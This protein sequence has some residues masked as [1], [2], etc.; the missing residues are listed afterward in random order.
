LQH[1]NGRKCASSAIALAVESLESRTHLSV[2]RDAAGWTVV[3]PASDTKVI[4]VS[5]SQGSDS[6]DGLATT[7]PIKTLAK[8]QSLV[9]DGF[10][11]WVL[12]K[13]GDTFESFGR[14]DKHGRSPQEPL[15][16]SAYGTGARPQINSGLNHGFL[17]NANSTNTRRIDNVV[18][19][20]LSFFANGYDGTNDTQGIAGFRLLAPSSNMTIEDCKIVGYKDNIVLG[21]ASHAVTD[22]TIRR[23]EILDSYNL[24][25]PATSHAQGIYISSTGANITIEENVLDHNGWRQGQNA[26][27]T[28]YN[29]NVYVYN[30]ATNVVVQ[31]NI[32]AEGSFYGIKFNSGGTATGNFLVR[33]AENIYLESAATVSDNVITEAVD[34]P[35]SGW[36]IGINTQKAPSATIQH[37]LITKVASTGGS[38]LIGIQL[39][40]NNTPF[41]GTISDNIIYNWK[42]TGIYVATPGNG[43]GSVQIRNTQIQMVASDT[44]ISQELAGAQSNFVYQGNTYSAGTQTQVNRISGTRQSLSNWISKTGE[45]TAKYQTL[46]YP[47]PTRDVGRYSASIG[48]AGTFDD[49]IAKARAMDKTTWNPAYMAQSVNSYMWGGFGSDTS[50]PSIVSTAFG[51]ET[52]P[53]TLDVKFSEN[54]SSP[55][56]IGLA[57]RN[58]ATGQIIPF[59]YSSYNSATTTARFTYSGTL[60]DGDY[61]TTIAAT[62]VTDLSHN[63]LSKD[64][65]STFFSLSG[66]ATRDRHVNALDFNV[67]AN[68]FGRSGATFSQGDFDYN[69][70]VDTNDFTLLSSRFNGSLASGGATPSSAAL[71]PAAI[72]SNATLFSDQ[73]ISSDNSDLSSV[74]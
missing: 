63:A 6:N 5:N 42:N 18:I 56:S 16:I 64:Y 26:D 30:G 28:F 72:T 61:V 68:N 11:D 27:R 12:L 46:S 3:T 45:A 70:R 40:N 69:G 54:V 53:L 8:A 47:D 44:A 10:A 35:T 57:V 38:H 33:N 66:D 23:C 49:F 55:A 50:G 31:N 52:Q 19:S 41:S 62:S 17:T 21:D 73:T 65:I 58:A 34:M 4:Y 67:M 36:G 48:G 1:R 22:M 32:I 43:A 51:Y 29:H 59:V 37:N 60:A 15:Y 13:R 39:Y 71:A 24:S 25:A 7:R 74:L 2:S 14:W 9:R 20:S